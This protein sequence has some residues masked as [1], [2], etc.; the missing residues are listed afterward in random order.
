MYLGSC[1]GYTDIA[2]NKTAVV[3]GSLEEEEAVEDSRNKSMMREDVLVMSGVEDEESKRLEG[4]EIPYQYYRRVLDG[5]FDGTSYCAKESVVLPSGDGVCI[6]IAKKGRSITEPA[7]KRARTNGMERSSG[8]DS[9]TA[10]T[11][12]GAHCLGDGGGTV[13]D[14]ECSEES[15]ISVE[16]K[17]K[18]VEAAM[19]RGIEIQAYR[20]AL[21]TGKAW[22]MRFIL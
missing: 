6:F 20:D 16:E 4:W 8:D 10:S 21:R 19:E 7:R 14:G 13:E 17:R 9:T 15:G 12:T 2:L 22:R 5:L 18:I 3:G 11:V 1:G